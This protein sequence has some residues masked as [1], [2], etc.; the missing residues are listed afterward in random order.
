MKRIVTSVCQ[1]SNCFIFTVVSY[2]SGLYSDDLPR[3]I[4]AVSSAQNVHLDDISPFCNCCAMI[5]SPSVLLQHF[6]SL[7]QPCCLYSRS[8]EVIKKRGLENPS[9]IYMVCPLFNYFT[10]FV[11]HTESHVMFSVGR[12]CAYIY[13]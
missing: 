1:I 4:A 8:S 3:M 7:G 9:S 11:H 12:D 2:C 5:L 6:F 13:F 10:K